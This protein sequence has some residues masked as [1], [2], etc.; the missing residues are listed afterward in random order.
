MI[1]A[2]VIGVIGVLFPSTII[3]ATVAWGWRHGTLSE[4]PQERY[5]WDFEQIVRRLVSH[6]RDAFL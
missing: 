2:V 6:D 1:I 5:D 3:L 4:T